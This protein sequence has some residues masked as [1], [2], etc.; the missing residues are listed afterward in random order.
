M[1]HGLRHGSG[2]KEPS[3][4]SQQNSDGRSYAQAAKYP[5]VLNTREDRPPWEG[6]MGP[7][8]EARGR[9][10]GAGECS[11]PGSRCE[12]Y[13][14]QCPEVAKGSRTDASLRMPGL[15]ALSVMAC[16]NLG[17]GTLRGNQ[18]SIVAPSAWCSSIWK[19]RNL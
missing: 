19:R 5:V 7:G 8:K 14:G 18:S 12:W 1:S 17:S 3:T 15:A 13:A 10:G 16:T 6:G 9:L 11:T 4:L 2:D